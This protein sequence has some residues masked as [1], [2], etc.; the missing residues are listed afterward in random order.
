[1]PTKHTIIDETGR[2]SEILVGRNLANAANLVLEGVGRTAILTQPSVSR[3]A[4]AVA[5][6]VEQLGLDCSRPDPPRQG[7]C[8]EPV[9]VGSRVRVAEHTRIHEE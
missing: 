8:K 5:E 3:L 2:I 1:M 7:R 9:T 4:A 6:G